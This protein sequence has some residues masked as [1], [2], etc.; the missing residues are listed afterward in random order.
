MSF[1][2]KFL[3]VIQKHK[4][5]TAIICIIFSIV[6]WFII[7]STLPHPLGDDMDYL[8]KRDFGALLLGAD[9]PYSVYYYGTDIA[10]DD[11]TGYFSGIVLDLPIKNKGS[12][13]NVW[14]SSNGKSLTVTYHK[15]SPGGIKSTNKKYLIAIT[16][17][18]YDQLKKLVK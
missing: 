1:T 8:G 2:N 5:I 16:N 15:F 14:L 9:K 17:S 11:I 6:S 7:S 13:A 12:Y 18:D 10:P 4:V 3:I